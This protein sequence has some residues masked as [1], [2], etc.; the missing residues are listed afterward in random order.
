MPGVRKSIVE[1]VKSE[2]R[3]L[4]NLS[5]GCCWILVESGRIL[6]HAVVTD[7]RCKSGHIREA[8]VA[9]QL[10]LVGVFMFGYV[11]R[12]RRLRGVGE[13]EVVRLVSHGSLGRQ[14]MV[15]GGWSH[16]DGRCIGF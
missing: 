15:G 16:V 14:D 4:L 11:M 7:F 9:R 2:Y 5:S 8:G 13:V 6:L 3:R 12:V 1:I 10:L